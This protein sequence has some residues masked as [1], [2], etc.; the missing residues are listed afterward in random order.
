MYRESRTSGVDTKANVP[1]GN[2]G[3]IFA[4]ADAEPIAAILRV[5][6]EGERFLVC[7]HARSGGD[8]VGSTLALGMLLLHMGKR[9]DLV[10]ADCIP[11]L[12]RRLPGTDS[13]RTALRVQ[14]P[15]DAAIQEILRELCGALAGFTAAS[16]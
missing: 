8:A 14:G 15:Y 12:Y 7:S 9:A 10:S 4:S 2:R 3:D 6:R 16:A 5:L 11:N 13:I 1:V